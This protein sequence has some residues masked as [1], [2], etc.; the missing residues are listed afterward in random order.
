MFV[1]FAEYLFFHVG[2]T[3]GLFSQLS[4]VLQGQRHGAGLDRWRAGHAR[5][6]G[7]HRCTARGRRHQ[8]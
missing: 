1:F 6:E 8:G 5:G 3:E 4:A 7:G 2:E